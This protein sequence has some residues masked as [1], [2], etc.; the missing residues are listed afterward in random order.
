M[1]K[2]FLLAAALVMAICGISTAAAQDEPSKITLSLAD[3]QQY[4]VQ[5]N[6]TLANASLDVRKAEASRWQAIASLLPQVKGTVDYSNYFGYEMNLGTMSISMPPY[7]TFGINTAIGWSGASFINVAVADISKKMADISLLKSER[8]VKDQVKT[9]YYSALVVSK[10]IGLLEE[11]LES[12]KRLHE[13]TVSSVKVGVAEQTSADQ[14]AVQ[15]A[16]LEATVNSTRRSLEL[17]YNSLRLALCLEDDSEIVLTQTLEDLVDMSE[18]QSVLGEDF[19]LENNY[20]YQLLEQSTDLAKKQ[21]SL[22]G[23]SN[24]PTLSVYHQ[25]SKKHY[26][27]DAMTMNMTPPN[28]MGITLSVPILTFG[29]ATA[30]RK[31]AVIAYEEQLN[32]M[33]TTEL[34]LKLQYRQLV[35]NLSSNLEK[36]DTQTKSVELAGRVFDNTSLKY[37]N[38]VSSSLELTTAATDL[39]SAE[40]SYVAALLEVV[41]AKISLET[42]LN[43]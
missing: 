37:E 7:S 17:A 23:W 5:H 20:D 22:T 30:A 14:I 12:L 34:S 11:N 16:S 41:N 8:D 24:G 33:A 18:I 28:M 1:M 25:Y 3:A 21:I 27:S 31:A 9:L 35:Y 15:V 43:K 36:L 38:G 13:M 10:T 42:L 40:S 2:R 32:T 39:I 19:V 26:F 29:K 4:A 6:R